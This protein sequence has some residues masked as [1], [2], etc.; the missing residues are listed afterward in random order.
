MNGLAYRTRQ[1]WQM[2]TATVSDQELE[3]AIRS[4]PPAARQLFGQQAV[5]DQHH[6]LRVHRWLTEA[7]CS[8]PDLLAAALLHDVGKS[9]W[10]IP[11]WARVTAVLLERIAPRLL[12]KLGRD[13]ARGWRRPFAA[14]LHHSE[15]SAQLAREAECSPIT[16]QI[17]LRH[18]CRDTGQTEAAPL[19]ALLQAA[20]NR[21]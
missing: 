5:T 2:M 19:L 12:E 1:F 16:Q 8:N 14:H 6:A 13:P 10:R 11:V 3:P 9:A 17:I 20:D 7:G 18:H 15:M 21:S 4:L